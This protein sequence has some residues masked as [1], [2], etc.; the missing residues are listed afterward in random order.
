MTRR[1]RRTHLLEAAAHLRAAGR[2]ELADDLT[3]EAAELARAEAIETPRP[4]A[5][6]TPVETDLRKEV[7]ALRREVQELRA[8]LNPPI[9]PR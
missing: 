1:Q 3:A 8:R 6:P 5:A 4:A 2:P 9:N 7:E